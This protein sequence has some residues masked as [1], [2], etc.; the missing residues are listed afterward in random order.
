MTRLLYISLIALAFVGNELCAGGQNRAGTAAAPEL[1]IPVG[2]RDM[3][4]G[5]SSIATPTGLSALHWNPAGLARAKSAANGL[6]STMSYLADI[7]VNYVAVSGRFA[8]LGS[9]ALDIKTLNFGEIPITTETSPDGSGATFSPTFFTL[10]LTYARILTDRITLGATS[11]YISNRIERVSAT[12]LSFSAGLQYADLGGIAGLDLG[13]AVKHIGARMQ[14]D[15][16]ALLHSGQLDGLRRP[17]AVYKVESSSADLP[18]IF[19]IGLGYHYTPADL[20]EM[21]F[22]SVFRHDNFAFDQWKIGTEYM[23][24]EFFAVRGGF[25]YAASADEDEYMFGTSFGFGLQLDLGTLE[26]VKIDYA[27]TAVDRFDALNT[28]TFQVGF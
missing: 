12:G 1:L 21:E 15:G 2:A 9:L 13:V 5:G 6:F 26:E 14:F 23:Y 10:G 4:L 27:Y 3:A 24:N 18:S 20:G 25:D 8:P 22:T 7:R 17:D 28:F 19:E 16:P 11:H